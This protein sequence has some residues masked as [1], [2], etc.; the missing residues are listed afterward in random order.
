MSLPLMCGDDLPWFHPPP[1]TQRGAS[2][3]ASAGENPECADSWGM[4]GGSNSSQAVYREFLQGDSVWLREWAVWPSEL[5]IP[6]E[7]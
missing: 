3:S 1:F 5:H 4:Q 6:R 2:V 7:C